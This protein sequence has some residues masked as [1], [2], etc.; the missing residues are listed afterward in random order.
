MRDF[1][2]TSPATSLGLRRIGRVHT[3]RPSKAGASPPFARLTTQQAD[4]SRGR[5]VNRMGMI[6]QV[7][8]E[9]AAAAFHHHATQAV[10][11][12]MVCLSP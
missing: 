6:W 10:R 11:I 9:Q 4:D 5:H 7:A 2:G 3:Q 12:Q 8:T 1:S